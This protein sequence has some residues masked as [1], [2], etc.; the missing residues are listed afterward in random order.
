LIR[1]EGQIR[2]RVSDANLYAC[3]FGVKNPSGTWMAYFV[4][5]VRERIADFEGAKGNTRRR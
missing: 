4:S 3:L 1:L 2:Y 5:V